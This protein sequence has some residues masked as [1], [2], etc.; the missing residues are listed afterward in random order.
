MED[1]FR[2]MGLV[3]AVSAY[4]ALVIVIVAGM[5]KTFEKAGQPGWACIIP[6]YNIMVILEITK[7]PIWWLI[8][9]LIPCVSIIAAILVMIDFAK[10]FGRGAGFGLGLTFLPFIFFPILGFGS[11]RYLGDRGVWLE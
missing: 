8:L 5:W 1:F 9:M 6:V 3:F 2:S 10:V 7:K 11:A 4:L